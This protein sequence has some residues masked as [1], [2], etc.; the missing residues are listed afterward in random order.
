[1]EKERAADLER[2]DREIGVIFAQRESVSAGALMGM[3]DFAVEKDL[4]MDEKNRPS[5]ASKYLAA[6]YKPDDR[7]AIVLIRDDHVIQR[8]DAVERFTEDSYQRWFERMNRDGY[9][10]HYSMN[11]LKPDSFSRTVNDIAHVRHIWL[12]V[13][14]GGRQAV[15][16]IL[17]DPEWPKVDYVIRT[18][19]DKYQLIWRAIGFQRNQIE[20][21]LKNLAKETG[22]DLAATDAARV[23]RLPGFVN[24]KYPDKPLVVIVDHERAMRDYTRPKDWPDRLYGRERERVLEPART[25]V[26]DLGEDRRVPERLLI[27][28][29]LE[30]APRV[31]RNDAGFRL[32]VQLRDNGYSREEAA[33]AN[34]AVPR[35]RSRA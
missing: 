13:D 25:P 31:G 28:R 6:N 9:N 22:A 3:G 15:D 19:P 16:R 26:R 7:I 20:P 1:L 33:G 4:I 29:A 24:N 12:D 35:Q 23:M 21:L 8:V 34:A 30:D 5:V 10:V 11:S 17:E 32:A 14:R 2:C 18:S 27:E